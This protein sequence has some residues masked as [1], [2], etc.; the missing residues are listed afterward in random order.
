MKFFLVVIALISSFSL[1]TATAANPNDTTQ[2]RQSEDELERLR[3]LFREIVEQT[4]ARIQEQSES[5]AAS[6]AEVARVSEELVKAQQEIERLTGELIKAEV[7]FTETNNS[8]VEAE[9]RI[10]QQTE[11]IAASNVEAAQ[12][13]EELVKAQQEIER[14]TLALVARV[15]ADGEARIACNVKSARLDGELMAAREQLNEMKSG[16]ADTQL[17]L[18]ELDTEVD[19]LHQAI[20]ERI[21]QL[22]VAATLQ[23]GTEIG[24]LR[25]KLEVTTEQ[26]NKLNEFVILESFQNANS[27][28]PDSDDLTNFSADVEPKLSIEIS[29]GDN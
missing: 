27:L 8:R 6:D 13:S 18:K 2:P 20:A 17:T 25:T 1:C 21:E 14:L 11:A 24:K 4:E 28:D 5:V 7:A 29:E 22:F 15:R 26:I 10:E 19:A 3:A 16:L 12:I 9:I 23:S